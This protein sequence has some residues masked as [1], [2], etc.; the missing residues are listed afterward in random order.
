MKMFDLT[1]VAAVTL[2]SFGC[3][4]STPAAHAPTLP[5][6]AIESVDAVIDMPPEEAESM[7]VATADLSGLPAA[8]WSVEPVDSDAVPSALISAWSNAQNRASCAPIVPETFGAADGAQARVS[9]LIEGGWAVEFDRGGLPGLARGGQ[10]CTRCGRGVFGIAGTGMSPDEVS[11]DDTPSFA[12]GSH[13]LV[14]ADE[15]E[16]VA[17]ATITV[18]GCVYQVWSFLGEE[19]LRELVGGL[20]RVEVESPSDTAVAAAN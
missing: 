18:E 15:G 9:T 7:D 8:P 10:T 20:R 2:F 4:S 5:M 13:L 14:E 17:A 1:A 3:A 6:A 16:T 11:E 12:D 19:H